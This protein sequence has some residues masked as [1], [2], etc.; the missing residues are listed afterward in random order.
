MDSKKQKILIEYLISS[1]DTFGLCQGIVKSNYF[2]P[3]FRNAVTFIKQY[4]EKYSTT[5]KPEQVEAETGVDLKFRQITPDEIEYCTTEIEGFCKKQALTQAILASPDLL[6]KGDFGT[7]EKN[8]KEA[9]LVSLNRDLGLSYFGSVNE[10]LASMLKDDPTEPTGWTAVDELLYGGISRQELILFSANSGGGKSITLAN[11]AYN[12]TKRGRDVLYLS[13]E[14]SEKIVAQ[15][16][17]TMFTGIGRKD[18]KN[19]VSEI[20]T[21]VEGEKDQGVGN[22][23]IKY[24]AT[25]TQANAIRAYLK[26]YYLHNGHYP[27][28]LVVDYM[29]KMSPNEAV[30]A[31]NV[32]EKDK[33]CAEQ[34]RQLG[35]DFNMFVA[36]ASQ[37]NREAVKATRHDHS[38]IAGG[39]SKINESDIYI[40]LTMNER[41]RAEGEI[42]FDLQKTR[43]SEG[44]GHKVFLKWN[45]KNLRITDKDPSDP[46]SNSAIMFVKRSSSKT[47]ENI[48]DTPSGDG[49]L[50]MLPTD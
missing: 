2:D 49:L 23:V 50:D 1:P 31:D 33:R 8:I 29:D 21:K 36:T 19:H 18:W 32:W 46:D 41:M 42:M 7:I 38:H 24:M 27:D 13:L 4:Y 48:I 11:L 30:S 14:L 12:F 25:G 40:S 43:N 39:I 20:A 3:E 26:E 17:D 37:L 35:V 47:V 44:V 28:M 22:L 34:L 15:R 16:F 9:I 45:G 10:R 6:N 5:P